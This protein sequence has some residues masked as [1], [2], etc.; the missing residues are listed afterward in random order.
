MLRNILAGSTFAMILS[1]SGSVAVC[2]S[3]TSC[4]PAQVAII[5]SQIPADGLGDVECVVGQLL[6]GG[7]MDPAQILAQCGPLL[8]SQLI[9]LAEDLLAT[10]ASV[11]DGGGPPSAD[12]GAA[13]ATFKPK[14]L[15]THLANIVLTDAQRSRVQTIHDAALKLVDGGS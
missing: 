9:T 10:P 12:G 7:L 14:L 5:D 15:P 1:A 13:V 3:E 6:Q 2:M 8:V 11:A 4:T